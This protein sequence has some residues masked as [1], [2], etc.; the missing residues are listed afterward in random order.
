MQFEYLTGGI[1]TAGFHEVVVN[2]RTLE[3]LK[4]AKS[5]NRSQWRISSTVFMHIAS[6]SE[7]K[8]LL[9]SDSEEV[10]N[11]FPPIFA[12]EQVAKE[13]KVIKLSGE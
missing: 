11:K 10:K 13:L 12:G 3:S 1:V 5:Q 4:N 6:D 8:P 2:D 9:S 7:L